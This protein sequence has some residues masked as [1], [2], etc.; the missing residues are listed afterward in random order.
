MH[1][2]TI[3][4][5]L[6]LPHVMSHEKD[7]NTHEVLTVFIFDETVEALGG[8]YFLVDVENGRIILGQGRTRLEMIEDAE[9]NYYRIEY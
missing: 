9:K 3:E 7:E 5:I 1:N 2:L 8:Q 6:N 4:M